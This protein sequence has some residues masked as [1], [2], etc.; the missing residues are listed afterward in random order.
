MTQGERERARAHARCR[1]RVL[2]ATPSSRKPQRSALE[3]RSSV[4]QV[5]RLRLDEA[6]RSLARVDGSAER[7]HVDDTSWSLDEGASRPRPP[8]LVG[9][10]SF[11]SSRARPTEALSRAQ[12]LTACAV[13]TPRQGRSRSP[14]INQARLS[15]LSSLSRDYAPVARPSETL[16]NR[17]RK[18]ER[19]Q[20][21]GPSGGCVTEL[22]LPSCSLQ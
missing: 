10:P 5:A 18:S 20:R 11:L 15:L 17:D 19:R 8:A 21:T 12:A 9:A 13:A 22:G 4:P 6:R 14:K 1:L 2:L 7:T 3:A 16:E